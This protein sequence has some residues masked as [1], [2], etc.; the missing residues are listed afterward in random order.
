MYKLLRI[1]KN[2]KQLMQYQ[3]IVNEKA[4]QSEKHLKQYE[5]LLRIKDSRLNQK[6]ESLNKD[7]KAILNEKQQIEREKNYLSGGQR[8]HYA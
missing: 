2:I 4:I 8:C 6:E 1:Q 3:N 7:E 5:S